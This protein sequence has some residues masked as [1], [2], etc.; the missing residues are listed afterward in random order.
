MTDEPTS[1]QMTVE[2]DPGVAPGAALVR[3]AGELDVYTAP[4]LRDAF[5]EL[6]LEELPVVVADLSALTF[7]D[8]SGLGVLV[9]V[10]KKLRPAGGSLRVVCGQ[11]P[12]MR[13]LEVTGLLGT[14]NVF[15]SV[16]DATAGT[17]T[18]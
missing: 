12:V 8:S 14:I 4:S 17:S 1:D 16:Q 6:P 10:H 13:M 11:G 18:S 3:V 5:V 15:A 9:G 2:V 7:M